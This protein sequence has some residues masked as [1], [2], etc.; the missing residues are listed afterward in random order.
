MAGQALQP[1]YVLHR[2]HYKESSLILDVFTLEQGKVS[3]IAKGGRKSKSQSI[4]WLQVF[5]PLLLSWTGRSDLK[6]LVSV[7]APNKAFRLRGQATYCAYYANELVLK[8]LPAMAPNQE[9]FLAYS[10][11]LESLNHANKDLQ[12]QAFSLRTFELQLLSSLGL[13]PDFSEDFLGEP[14]E[15]GNSYYLSSEMNFVPVAN[16]SQ[17][18]IIFQG[19]DVLAVEQALGHISSQGIEGIERFSEQL[20]RRNMRLLFMHLVDIALDGRTLS[21]R[22]LLKQFVQERASIVKK[23]SKDAL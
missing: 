23:N 2:R 10:W 5:Q 12:A 15:E 1:C 19:S 4:A 7:E 22:E 14:I 3:V 17:S 11:C 9:A 13:L 21:S 6:T 8:L 20:N 16:N 18:S